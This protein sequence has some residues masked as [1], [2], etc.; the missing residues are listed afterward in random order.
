MLT[1]V[2]GL[3]VTKS[4]H[5]FKVLG[6]ETRLLRQAKYVRQNKFAA[7]RIFYKYSS[8]SISNVFSMKKYQNCP[9]NLVMPTDLG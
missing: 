9:R 2:E 5:K 4:K 6:L 1:I 7:F 3:G 8:L